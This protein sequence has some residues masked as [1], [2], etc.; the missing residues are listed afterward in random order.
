MGKVYGRIIIE[1][2]RGI[3]EDLMGDE[4]SGFRKGRGC[5]DQ[6]FTIKCLFQKFREKGRLLWILKRR[7]IG[8]TGRHYGRYRANMG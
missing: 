7:I 2:V 4:Q 5:M 3:T 1:R 6:I 8:W